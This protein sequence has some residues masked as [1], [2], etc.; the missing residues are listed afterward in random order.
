MTG[1]LSELLTAPPSVTA[2]FSPGCSL[3]SSHPCFQIP[4]SAGMPLGTSPRG[5]SDANTS[6]LPSLLIG[7][8]V[9]KMF[10]LQVFLFLN[11]QLIG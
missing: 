8:I 9:Y 1:P 7:L 4:L 3:S 2:L 10:K 5:N 11:I 6:L